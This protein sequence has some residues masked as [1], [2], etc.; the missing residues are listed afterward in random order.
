MQPL[1]QQSRENVTG[2]V[3]FLPAGKRFKKRQYNLYLM[4][5]LYKCL[6]CYFILKSSLMLIYIPGSEARR[7]AIPFHFSLFSD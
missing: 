1:S 4:M 2:T 7:L 3:S 5:C 6:T